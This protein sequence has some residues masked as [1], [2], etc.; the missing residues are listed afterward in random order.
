[1]NQPDHPADQSPEVPE[2]R[3]RPCGASFSRHTTYEEW[4]RAYLHDGTDKFDESEQEL[5][6]LG[7]MDDWLK[8]LA[9]SWHSSRASEIRVRGALW[10]AL[11][12]YVHDHDDVE[13]RVLSA[14]QK[15]RPLAGDPG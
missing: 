2:S 13:P 15:Y 3:N 14:W 4:A 5:G 10:A 1:M 7:P 12:A 8:R 11:D 9:A 6:D